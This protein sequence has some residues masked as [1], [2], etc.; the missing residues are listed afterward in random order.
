MATKD[1]KTNSSKTL[2]II[3]KLDLGLSPSEVAKLLDIAPSTVEQIQQDALQ[4]RILKRK[5]PRSHKERKAL[6]KQVADFVRAAK[7]SKGRRESE[8][9][10]EAAQ[11]FSMSKA[12][13]RDACKEFKVDLDT[14]GWIG[15]QAHD[16]KDGPYLTYQILSRLIEFPET[17][18]S[19]IAEELEVSR[20]MVNMVAVRARKSG[21]FV[22]IEKRLKRE[23]DREGKGAAKRKG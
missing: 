3:A 15:G 21:V 17:R 9:L 13:V 6:R 4:K 20:Q 7:S 18:E 1:S 2:E 5:Q 10:E 8:V 23:I 12:R 19:E 22:A 16:K 11:R 14:G